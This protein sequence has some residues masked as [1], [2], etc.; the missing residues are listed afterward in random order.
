[1][2]QRSV[3]KSLPFLLTYSELTGMIEDELHFNLY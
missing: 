2:K 1:M 3:F